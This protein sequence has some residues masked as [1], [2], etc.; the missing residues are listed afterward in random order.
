MLDGIPFGSARRVVGDGSC[1]AKWGAQLSLDFG[2]PGPGPATVAATRVGE[3]QKPGSM[4]MATRSLAFPPGGDRMG[5]EGR[6]VM[7][8]ADADRAA[9]VQRV[10]DAIRDA[11]PA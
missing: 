10:I 3:N 8:H 9:I 7:R 5:R 1:D 6:C 4:A 2:L 11:H